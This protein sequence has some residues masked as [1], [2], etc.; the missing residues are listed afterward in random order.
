MLD[1]LDA[2]DLPSVGCQRLRLVEGPRAREGR[3]GRGSRGD[4]A[5][6]RAVEAPTAR[7]VVPDCV[8]QKESVSSSV[9]RSRLSTP[10]R[11]M[12]RPTAGEMPISRKVTPASLVFSWAVKMA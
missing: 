7:V 10:A 6:S 3:S 1:R 11:W 2:E 5:A 9:A 8:A 4:S 12:T